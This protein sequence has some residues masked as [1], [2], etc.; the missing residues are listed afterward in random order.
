MA[1]ST[2]NNTAG[3]EYDLVDP[4]PDRLL[5]KICHLPSRDPYLSVCC[6]HLFCRSC[7]ENVAVSAISIVC[8]ICRCEDFV[9]FPNKAVDRDIKSLPVHCTNRVIGCEWQGE[10]NDI[11]SHLKNN[12][13][14]HFELVNCS[15]DCGK[16][17][18][19]R[20]LTS[21][22]KITCQRRKVN[23]QYC[24]R[25]GEHHIIEGEHKNRCPK[26]PLPCPNKC[27]VGTVPREGMKKHREKCQ[28]EIINCSN[29][30]GE[31]LERQFLANHIET[32][33]SRRKVNCQYCHDSGELQFIDGW[34][35]MKCPKFPILC[36]NKCSIG[37]VPRKDMKTHRKECPLEM[38]QCEYY[39]V[40]CET[41]MARKDQEKHK[42]ENIEEH[43]MKANI[44]LRCDLNDTKLELSSTKQDL[45]D[46]TVALADAKCKLTDTTNQLAIAL[47]RISRLE[48][49]MYLTTDKAV[50]KTTSH[51]AVIESSLGWS[52]KL[53]AMAMKSQSGDQVCPVI[54]KMSNFDEL[55]KKNLVL[56]S[57]TFYTDY[58]GYRMSVHII[59]RGHGFGKG[60]HLS[61]Y[62]YLMKGLNDDKLLWPLKENFEIKLLNQINDSQHHSAVV[63]YCSTII[64]DSS[65]KCRATE[66]SRG[67]GNSQFISNENLNKITTTCQFLKDDCLFL[68][69]TKL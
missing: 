16:M 62:L 40:G 61:C 60:T 9:A 54:L 47:Q 17:V 20:Y 50:T 34:H 5:C 26:F 14:C 48:A 64:E 33:C 53:A 42:N 11:K 55:K 24:R 13:G 45:I 6:G 29:Y 12:D 28:L 59:P 23:C 22:V 35:K 27:E 4:L 2:L 1:I 39:S 67:L 66:G 52:V 10:L 37:Y 44:A 65:G 41:R 32:K 15:N 68:Q 43:L 46:A 3:Y 56:Y 57:H 8:P 7:L 19:R 69:I 63:A 31:K 36:P 30:C 51:A 58:K 49:L 25:S 38:I 18:Q 21:H